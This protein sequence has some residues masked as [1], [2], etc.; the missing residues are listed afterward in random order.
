MAFLRGWLRSRRNGGTPQA[1][2]LLEAA[3]PQLPPPSKVGLPLGGLHLRPWSVSRLAILF[4]DAKRSPSEVTFREA[5]HARHCLSG[6]WLTAPV[7]LLETLYGG[8][9]GDLQRQLLEGPLATQ[10]LASD[11]KQWR[12][13]LSQKL[14]E[15]IDS[16]ERVNVLLALMPYF[17]PLGMKVESPLRFVPDWLLKDYAIYCDPDLKAKLQKPV[18]YL[19]PAVEGGAG[20]LPPLP[21]ITDRRGEEAMAWFETPEL[22][23]RMVALIN[24][25]GLDPSDQETR[26]ELAGLRNTIA[27]LWLD[28]SSNELE[29][30]YLTAVGSVYRSLL[31]SG[32]GADL[33]TEQDGLTRQ[34][35]APHVADL[36][37][38]GAIN[39]LLAALLFFPREKIEIEGGKEFVPAWLL[40]QL[41]TLNS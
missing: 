23:Q 5:R 22:V 32:F 28:V 26:Q 24:L 25:Y 29:Q 21:L 33:V 3:T 37:Q 4:R 17:P 2:N 10:D 14:R 18:G 6:F 7:D 9:L 40:K 35:L 27:Q 30:L 19:Q 36:R 12:D 11:E 8:A 34:A 20:G 41:S 13:Q 31:M 16:S 38:P 15:H 1:I 39:S